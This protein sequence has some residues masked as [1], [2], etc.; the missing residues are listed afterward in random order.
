[1]TEPCPTGNQ[2]V[3]PALVQ[4]V[5]AV[6]DHF[7]SAWKADQRPHLEDYLGD[8]PEPGQSVLLRELIVVE[9]QYRRRGGET[10]VPTEYQH[11]FP[12]HT[13]MIG[14]LFC[15]EV[16]RTTVDFT[17]PHVSLCNS[18]RTN[19]APDGTVDDPTRLGRYRITGR[20]GW[21]NFGLVYQGFDD[22][23]RR[24]VA[25]KVPQRHRISS[26]EDVESYIA[27]ARTLAGLDHPGIVPV[28]DVG[29]TEDGLCYLVTKLVA[30]S[31]LRQWI[32]DARPSVA[33]AVEIVARVA[34][35][36]QHAHHRGLVH[37][38]VKPANILL[39]AEGNPFLTDFGLALREEDFAQ[40][41]AFAGTPAY[42]SPEQA[43]GEGHRVDA[44]TDV[45]SLG[46]V[47][48]EL[49]TG[50]RPYSAASE[51]DLLEQI[52]T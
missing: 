6:C 13:E 37:R 31:D 4:R 32:Q 24:D 14:D 36:L 5:D 52:K 7:E 27:E 11:R 15:A 10:P 41:P 3:S 8:I 42:M 25:I 18:T 1:M 35:A 45:Y 38:D 44:R 26:P 40:G 12:D 17:L 43:R 51:T 21:G 9:L 39:D 19:M 2:V 16:K 50:Q 48:Y 22:E 33:V 28:Y 29:H 49:L 20:I 47:F 30:G 46:V 23:L 34:E